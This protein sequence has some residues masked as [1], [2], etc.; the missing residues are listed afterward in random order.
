M[1]TEVPVQHS[2]QQ[3]AAEQRVAE[4]AEERERNRAAG[5]AAD[6]PERVLKRLD[7]L[8]EYYAGQAT[9]AAATKLREI[10]ESQALIEAAEAPEAAGKILE[11]IINTKDF[12]DFRYL[13]LGLAAGRAVARVN[14]RDENRRLGFGTGSMV[15]PALLLTNHHVLPNAAIART[16]RVE[17]DFQEDAAGQLMTPRVFALDPATFF[18]A[19]DELDFALVA[20]ARSPQLAQ[21]GFNRLVEAQGK[22]IVGEYVTIIQH[23][24]GLPK[25]VALRENQVVDLLPRFLHYETDTEPGS[26]GSPVFNDQWQVVGLHHAAVPRGEGRFINEGVRISQIVSFVRGARLSGARR[27]LVDQIGS[28]SIRLVTRAAPPQAGKTN[29]HGDAQPQAAPAPGVGVSEARLT[30]PVEITVRIAPDALT[31]TVAA[32]AM[33]ER[34]PEPPEPDEPEPDDDASEAITIDPDYATRRGYDPRFLGA[35]SVPLPRLSQAQRADAASRTSGPSPRYVLPYHNFSVVMNARRRLAYFTAVN[36]DGKLTRRLTREDDR[37][38]LDPRIRS[39]QQTGEA[40]YEDNDLDRG[41]LVRRLD[42]AWATSRSAAKRANDD[43][44]HFTN[45]TPQHKDFNQRQTS[46]AGIEDYILENAETHDLK[47]NVFTGPVFADDDEAYRGVKLP[48]QFWKVVVM[49]KRNGDLSATGYLLSQEALLRD[50]EVSLEEFS[51][52][53]YR[54][55]Q[56]PVRRIE[57]LTGLSFGDLTDVDPLEQQEAATEPRPIDELEEIRL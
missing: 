27:S 44:F 24:S 30:I 48:R 52:G 36:I 43:T 12:V 33:P 5:I 37:W 45:C 17:F 13:E 28:E 2:E 15:S 31:A 54:T 11:K 41:H 23:P 4:R 51:Y 25:Q 16:S 47:V 20:V 18:L 53:E 57:E 6:T 3:Q 40:V 19:D 50:L 46:W 1:A 7:R 32:P 8:R 35:G 56:V 39:D 42:P 21:F 9:E 26:S 49:A 55:F 38:I 22:V 10:D 34:P 14:I 29:G